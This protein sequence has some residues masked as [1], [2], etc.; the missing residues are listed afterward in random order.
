MWR[1]IAS[2]TCNDRRRVIAYQLWAF[3]VDLPFIFLGLLTLPIIYRVPGLLRDLY[4]FYSFRSKWD[5]RYATAQNFARAYLDLIVFPGLI[6]LYL[7]G[8]RFPGSLAFLSVLFDS[9]MS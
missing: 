4:Q 7:T 2:V 3:L 1:R 9:H 8:Y 5:R 6:I